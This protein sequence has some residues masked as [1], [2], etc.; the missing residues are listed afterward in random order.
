MLTIVALTG[1]GVLATAGGASAAPAS[2]QGLSCKLAWHDANTAGIKCTG[3]P[4]IGAAKCKNGRTA[5]GAVAASGTT[6]YAY[7]TSLNSSQDPRPV[8]GDPRVTHT[9]R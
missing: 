8:D 6:S 3:G 7:C 5:Q 2:P 1:S 4:F 9:T